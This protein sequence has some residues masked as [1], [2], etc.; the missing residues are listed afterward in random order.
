MVVRGTLEVRSS[1]PGAPTV[2]ITAGGTAVLPAALRTVV[3]E[4]SST[5]T[6]LRVTLP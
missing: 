1:D 4:A 5:V 2:S 6:M 3:A